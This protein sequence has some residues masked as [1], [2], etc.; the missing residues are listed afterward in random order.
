[1]KKV[2]VLIIA[3]LFLLPLVAS[4]QWVFEH[5]MPADS[6]H[7]ANAIT[8]GLAV[9]PDG[10]LWSRTGFAWWT[11][12]EGEDT[13]TVDP[14]WIINP[15]GEVI[16]SIKS[17]VIDGTVT[18]L[19]R[20]RGMRTDHE[21]NILVSENPSG[22][23]SL[24]RINYQTHELM[25][26]YIQPEVVPLTTPGVDAFGNIYLGT[27]LPDVPVRVLNAD[28]E[29]IEFAAISQSGVSRTIE[30]TQDG[31]TLFYCAPGENAVLKYTRDSEFDPWSTTPDT[32]LHGMKVRSAMVNRA[33]GNLWVDAGDDRDIPNQYEGVESNWEGYTWY[34]YDIEA[35]EVVSSIQWFN[36]ENSFYKSIEGQMTQVPRGDGAIGPEPRAVAFSADGTIGYFGQWAYAVH[37]LAQKWSFA[38]SVRPD[39]RAIAKDFI[40][41]QNYPNPFNPATEIGFT[42][43]DAG[44]TLLVVY[45]LLG[46]EVVTLVNEHMQPGSY[47]VTFDASR[48]PS[49]T[50]LYALESQGQR[51]IKKMVL[52]K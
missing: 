29:L 27:V 39:D 36:L 16:D 34:E 31:L 14:I 2:T 26:H 35:D 40:L 21:G 42:L 30:V 15:E 1:M 33:T 12:I 7:T 25:N 6:N 49:G 43:T 8:T 52:L 22:I 50:Y 41:S 4:A 38:T 51:S 37:Q 48:L 5:V 24:Y 13:I 9:D 23:S 45:D 28:F 20:A 18:P 44:N 46:R 32:I 47:I 11:L 10:N 3:A 17:V 19:K